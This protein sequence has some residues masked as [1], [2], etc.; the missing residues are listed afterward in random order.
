MNY[1][2]IYNCLIHKRTHIDVLSCNY[3]KHHVI[4]KACSGLDNQSNLVKLT[5]KEHLFAHKILIKIYAHTKY[6]KKMKWAYRLMC[7]TRKGIK[8]TTNDL[9]KARE[10][11]HG[12]NNP[13]ASLEIR[14]KISQTLMNHEVSLE[15]RQKQSLRRKGKPPSNK[16]KPISEKQRQDLI[17]RICINNGQQNRYIHPQ[18]PIPNGWKIGLIRENYHKNKIMITNGTINKYIEQNKPIPSGWKRGKTSTYESFIWITNGISNKQLLTKNDPIPDGW[19]VGFTK[20]KK[21]KKLV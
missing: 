6:E 20:R 12:K 19:Y 2:K 17:G 15:T 3:E 21:N 1:C 5:L 18:D 7:D 4:P 10:S 14:Q 11:I 9:A 13:C 8:L 16:G